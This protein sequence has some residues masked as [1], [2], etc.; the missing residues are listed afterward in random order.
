MPFWE[1][2]QA[3]RCDPDDPKVFRVP[4]SPESQQGFSTIYK[5]SN[6]Y[7]RCK[8]TI[9]TETGF[10]R[11][12]YC[13]SDTY[14]KS[15]KPNDFLE[16]KKHTHYY[17]IRGFLQPAPDLREKEY[18]LSE[19]TKAHCKFVGKFDIS[20]EA[21]TSPEMLNLLRSAFAEGQ[22]NPKTSPENFTLYSRNT[23]RT[24]FIEYSKTIET[25]S[26]NKLLNFKYVCILADAG[27]LGAK[28]YLLTAYGNPNCPGPPLIETS[29]QH[30]NGNMISYIHALTKSI[31]NLTDKGFVVAGVVCDNLPVQWQ[32]FVQTQ[33]KFC[34]LPDKASFLLF[35]CSCH[36]IA[37]AIKDASEICPFL[38][39][40]IQ[41]LILFSQIFRSKP[42]CTI[43]HQACPQYCSTRWNIVYDIALWIILHFDEIYSV[44]QDP[45]IFKFA[46][47]KDNI[48][49]VIKS[50][51]VF[52]P[53]IIILMHPFKLI[54]KIFEGD[55]CRMCD[56]FPLMSS[57]IYFGQTICSYSNFFREIYAMIQSCM[58]QRLQN[59]RYSHHRYALFMVT[60][61]GRLF[62]KDVIRNDLLESQEA[63]TQYFMEHYPLKIDSEL[64]NFCK[65]MVSKNSTFYVRFNMLL[66]FWSNDVV[67][68]CKADAA[69]RAEELFQKPLPEELKN[70][71]FTVDQNEN[72]KLIGEQ[73]TKLQSFY[74]SIG[75]CNVEGIYESSQKEEYTEHHYPSSQ[76]LNL[77]DNPPHDTTDPLTISQSD[78]QTI[79][80]SDTLTNDQRNSDDDIPTSV[81]YPS[82]AEYDL[83]KFQDS[84]FKEKV[85]KRRQN[86]N[87]EIHET[88]V[89]DDNLEETEYD[90]ITDEICTKQT[91]IL[92]TLEEM[93]SIFKLDQEKIVNFFLNTWRNEERTV[94][95][96]TTGVSCPPSPS[97]IQF[98]LCLSEKYENRYHCAGTVPYDGRPLSCGSKYGGSCLPPANIGV[99]P[100]PQP[101]SLSGSTGIFQSN[102]AQT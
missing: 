88:F 41:S 56:T 19:T 38:D 94:C 8:H 40:C 17:G 10:A 43:L 83:E 95:G 23:F 66:H 59:C 44:L 80:Q 36:N 76:C 63:L 71:L 51:F 34:N 29:N 9:R 100:Y 81:E 13:V 47:L 64:L 7:W 11:C 99:L 31:E 84:H 68:Y 33:K 24:I 26:H 70:V 35:S 102:Q 37:L 18:K 79:S 39:E 14:F 78:T 3:K 42:I 15:F 89:S 27:K 16:I 98:V 77:L 62:E 67:T 32:A 49:T 4:K 12:K 22:K 92:S 53:S 54:S 46:E 101:K 75:S 20:L 91:V 6:K 25:I 57:A 87:E 96:K 52:S 30:F 69:E 97:C 90:T 65:L 73:M 48:E 2:V 21:A 85:R 61:Q 55:N 86:L 60:P 50:L 72:Q 28:N 74:S 82:P 1:K 58:N 45:R 5:G 93:A